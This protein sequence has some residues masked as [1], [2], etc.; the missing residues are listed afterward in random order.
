MFIIAKC[1][2]KTIQNL[3]VADQLQILSAED[4]SQLGANSRL[5]GQCGDWASWSALSLGAKCQLKW[6]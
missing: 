6:D 5:S 4:A 3:K 1:G 2:F